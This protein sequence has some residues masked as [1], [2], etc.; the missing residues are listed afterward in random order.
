MDYYRKPNDRVIDDVKLKMQIGALTLKL[1]EN[2]KKIDDLI[3]VDKNIKKD[4]SSN[5]LK[6]DNNKND[7]LTNSGQ[8]N[9][10]EGNI[11]SN[12][13]KLNNMDIDVEKDIYT[14]IF[15]INNFETTSGYKLIFETRID[16]K[17]TKTGVIKI[18]ANYEYLQLNNSRH[19][20]VYLFKNN[21][22]AFKE[23]HINHY[24][25]IVNDE[26]SIPAIECENVDLIIFAVNPSYNGSKITLNKGNVEFIYNDFTKMLKTDYNLE[27]INT[28]TSNI[29]DNSG[30]INTNKSNISS[31]LLKI[32]TNTSSISDNLGKIGTNK[33]DISD[34]SGLISTNK[35]DISDNSG[36]I[37]TNTSSISDNLEKINNIENGIKI[38]IEPYN[39]TFI[40]SNRETTSGS[41]LTFEKIINF[42]FSKDGFF[43]IFT[44]CNY[45]YDTK[46]NF[47]HSYHFFNDNNELIKKKLLQIIWYQMLFKMT[48]N[49]K[50][51]IH[52]H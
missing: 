38:L 36:L 41:Q 46:Y 39:E 45:E 24:S 20:H 31:N 52:H 44:N 7:I 26:F 33:S 37:N 23:K 9:T 12:S 48:S 35:S 32:D 21:N 47:S 50:V 10:N 25:N 40:F 34:N 29:S 2:N 17:F 16:F 30:L 3:G 14:K 49:L 43:N 5:T 13:S 18:K 8:I 22:T 42:N 51:L 11:S 19:V 15:N 28:N 1:S 4:I 27:K 6:I